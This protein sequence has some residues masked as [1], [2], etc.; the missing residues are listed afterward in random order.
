MSITDEMWK[1]MRQDNNLLV[2]IEDYC[3][4]ILNRKVEY[5]H[6]DSEPEADIYHL[7]GQ[8]EVATEILGMILI[9]RGDLP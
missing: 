9:A 6:P 2:E 3:K 7:H 1:D 4:D 8:K 5:G